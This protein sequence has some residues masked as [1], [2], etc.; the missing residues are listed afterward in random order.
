M[1]IDQVGN[2]SAASI[3]ILLG[4]RMSQTP[5]KRGD[6]ICLVGFGAGFTWSSILLEWS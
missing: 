2:T 5:F 1:N 3:P 6:L 4:Q